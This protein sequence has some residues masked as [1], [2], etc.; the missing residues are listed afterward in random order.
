MSENPDFPI[1]TFPEPEMGETRCM[2]PFCL[3][4]ENIREV[5]F[6]SGSYWCGTCGAQMEPPVPTGTLPRPEAPWGPPLEVITPEEG[7]T[8]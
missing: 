8:S 2:N 6:G 1:E 7:E 5:P 4:K 3:D